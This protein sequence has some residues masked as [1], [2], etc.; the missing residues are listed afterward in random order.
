MDNTSRV[1]L[2][3]EATPARF[4]QEAVAARRMLGRMERLG[5]RPQSL[6]GDKAY[7]SGEFL[8]WLLEHGIQ[9]HIPVINRHHQTKGCFTREQF[10][11]MPEQNTYYC[12]QGKPLHY[13]GLARGSQG[14]VYQSTPA[15]CH[16]CPQKEHCT[17]GASRKLFVHWH[18]SARETTRAMAGTPT[19]E[20]S[21]RA[22]YRIEALFAE[23]KQ[24]M[25]L[26]RVRLRRLWNVA[27]QFLLAATAQNVKRLV[28]FLARQQAEPVPRTA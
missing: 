11:Y 1:I 9:P 3:V 20:C 6:G 22:R 5:L 4:S 10:R 25:H 18:E 15:Q 2:D 14:Y 23:L 26:N 17:R 7:G 19:Y 16:G 27:E 12:P 13:R 24:R 8:A 21:R 28:K